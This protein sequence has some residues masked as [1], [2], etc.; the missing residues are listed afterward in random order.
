MFNRAILCLRCISFISYFLSLLTYGLI[1]LYVTASGENCCSSK[2]GIRIICGFQPRVIF[3]SL[4]TV[5]GWPSLYIFKLNLTF[6]TCLKTTSPQLS[7]RHKLILP[8]LI[9]D[10][11]QKSV[12]YLGQKYITFYLTFGQCMILYDLLCRTS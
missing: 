7:I 4:Y 2:K 11:F 8:F 1:F 6:P 5:E 12:F 9:I 3:Q 10:I